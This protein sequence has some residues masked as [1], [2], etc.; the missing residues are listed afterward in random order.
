M[1]AL[2][3]VSGNAILAFPSVSSYGLAYAP[4]R[5]ADTKQPITRK[6]TGKRTPE[7]QDLNLR[8]RVRLLSGAEINIGDI[9]DIVEDRGGGKLHGKP[10]LWIKLKLRSLRKRKLFKYGARIYHLR[11]IVQTGYFPLVRT[12]PDKDI[13]ELRKKFKNLPSDNWP[14]YTHLNA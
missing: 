11:K 14:D 6:V 8:M 13:E 5:L 9:A 10:Y 1:S 12:E 3:V 4:H 7:L 2:K